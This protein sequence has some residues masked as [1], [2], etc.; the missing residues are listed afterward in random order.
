MDSSLL[1]TAGYTLNQMRKS[2]Q[3]LQVPK[4]RIANASLARR[5]FKVEESQQLP[6]KTEK[7]ARARADLILK[8]NEIQL[9]LDSQVN[10]ATAELTQNML[11]SKNSISI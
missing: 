8:L 11:Y 1:K 6:L 5:F 4:Q 7:N 3:I 10:R 2:L 9:K